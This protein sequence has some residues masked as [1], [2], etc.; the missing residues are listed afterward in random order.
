M[1]RLLL[2]NGYLSCFDGLRVWV[3][4]SEVRVSQCYQSLTANSKT[5]GPKNS[6]GIFLGQSYFK[7]VLVS[8]NA[9]DFT[10]GHV[11]AGDGGYWHGWR[12]HSSG[13]WRS[14]HQWVARNQTLVIVIN[15]WCNRNT[16]EFH[17]TL[18]FHTK[19][20]CFMLFPI[21]SWDDRSPLTFRRP[22]RAV[23]GISCTAGTN[24]DIASLTL[25]R[26]TLRPVRSCAWWRASQMF[27]IL[28]QLPC[29]S[30]AV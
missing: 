23:P 18:R 1:L 21:V 16:V 26:N 2:V 19:K 17:E 9:W 29:R 20:C 3:Q 30:L 27:L 4:F 13:C 12:G 28:F 6:N 11:D 8:V 22:N 5:G 14:F 10:W 15:K 25:S 24:G 7:Q